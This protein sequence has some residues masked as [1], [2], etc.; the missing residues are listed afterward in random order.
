[1]VTALEGAGLTEA[2]VQLKVVYLVGVLVEAILYGVYL[3][4][5]IAALPVLFRSNKFKSFPATVFVMGNTLM[6]VLISAHTSQLSS[7]PLALSNPSRHSFYSSP[8]GILLFQ[9]VVAFAYQTD[10]HGPLRIYNDMG[11][12]ATYTGPYL[13]ATVLMIGDFLLIYRCFLL[14]QRNYWVILV[15]VVLAA[16]SIG[17]HI[18]TLVFVRSVSVAVI[19]VRNWPIM[20]VA[21]ICYI[22]Q[23]SLTTSLIVY[24]IFSQFRQTRDLGLVSFHAPAVLPIM[25]IILESAVVYTTGM[26]AL[27]VLAGLDH[28]A[29]LALHSCMIPVTGSVFVL[30]ALRIHVVQEEAA[31]TPATAS[32]M[33]TWLF[34]EP[35]SLDFAPRLV[36]RD[37]RWHAQT[38]TL[39][40]TQPSSNSGASSPVSKAEAI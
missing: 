13:G 9:S 33:P 16:L 12:W 40:L 25:R 37:Q 8:L 10:V 3:C 35:K 7:P 19:V 28:P 27:V 38:Q 24:R 29:R 18:A 26:M 11:Y 17:L 23:T 14:W 15:P 2:E 20:L 36:Q 4:F 31:H 5:F 22:A 1:M 32:L 34:D 30:M 6:F 21:P 39:P